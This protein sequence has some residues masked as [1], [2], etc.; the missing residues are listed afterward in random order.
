MTEKLKNAHGII[1]L[2]PF[3]LIVSRDKIADPY[4]TILLAITLLIMLGV[5]ILRYRAGEVPK[6]RLYIMIAFIALGF[7]LTAYY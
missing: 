1:L 5:F 6:S 7:I 2:L 4:Y 3:L